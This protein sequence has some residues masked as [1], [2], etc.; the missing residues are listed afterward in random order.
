MS[1]HIHQ[2]GDVIGGR[3]EIG[4]YVGAGGMQEVYRTFDKLL[5]REVAL[6]VPKNK[7]AEKRFKRSAVVSARINHANVAKTLDYL[8]EGKRSYLIEEY[9]DGCDLGQILRDVIHVLDPLLVARLFHHLA[10]GLA[11]SHHAGVVHRDLKP[12][13]IMVVGGNA[14]TDVKITDFGIAKL[15][16]EEIDEAV[17]GGDSSI[18]ASQTAI[19]ALPYMAPEIIG[20]I[21][22]A[23]TSADI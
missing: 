4:S 23:D 17:E 2:K 11:A 10:R 18:T 14:L 21:S 16:A 6:K 9:I 7:S 12:S 1:E 19:G 8:E 5:S 15:A 3:Y 20:S 13:N 22:S